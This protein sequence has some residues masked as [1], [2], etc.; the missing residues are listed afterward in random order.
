MKTVTTITMAP[1]GNQT[2][3]Q[4]FTWFV[5]CADAPALPPL[6]SPESSQP[7][8][9]TTSRFVPYSPDHA[10]A[11]APDDA[12]APLD[13]LLGGVPSAAPGEDP[14]LA[15]LLAAGQGMGLDP[16]GA[17]Y[18][19]WG[20]PVT[21]PAA[22]AAA[23]AAEDAA[24]LATVRNAEAE[25]AA[26]RHAEIARLR[27]EQRAWWDSELAKAAAETAGH[28][29]QPVRG[30]FRLSLTLPPRLTPWRMAISWNLLLAFTQGE[31]RLLQAHAPQQLR[32][33]SRLQTSLYMKAQSALCGVRS[34]QGP[35]IE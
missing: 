4:N 31:E 30:L 20:R 18:D 3:T 32:N 7:L 5:P 11:G 1:G 14:S 17:A 21:N 29:A 16:G 33:K 19:V 34:M 15:A 25:A 23:D 9:T 13:A 22:E 6:G 8:V 35:A 12:A 10:G 24:P 2:T 28:L 27:A 26:V